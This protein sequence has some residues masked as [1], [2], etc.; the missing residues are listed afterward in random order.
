MNHPAVPQKTSTAFVPSALERL[1]GIHQLSRDYNGAD[2]RGHRAR[3]WELVR[4]HITEIEALMAREDP[5]YVTETGDL[6]VLCFEILLEDGADADEVLLRCLSRYERKL[7]ALI[8]RRAAD[9]S[10]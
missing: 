1:R 7:Q 8:A 10:P 9:S 5:H 2:P 6:A 4:K 3:L